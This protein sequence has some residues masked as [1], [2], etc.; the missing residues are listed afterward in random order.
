MSPSSPPLMPSQELVH[1]QR[2]DRLDE[3]TGRLIGV[4]E[5]Q[6]TSDDGMTEITVW[7]RMLSATSGS[8]LTSLLGECTREAELQ[9][10]EKNAMD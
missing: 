8:L 7:Q 2:H 4:S 3:G 9:C 10:H 1:G 6:S 5:E